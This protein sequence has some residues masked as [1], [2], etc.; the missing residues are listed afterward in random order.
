MGLQNLLRN[1]VKKGFSYMFSL[2]EDFKSFL[3]TSPTSWHAVR[4]VGNRLSMKDFHPL[5]ENQPWELEKGKKYFVTRGGSIGT[6]CL[7]K[8]APS[9][10][11]LMAAHTDSPSFK[12]KPIPDIHQNGMSL[13]EVESYGS[14]ILHSWLNRDIA[15]AGRIFFTNKKDELQEELVFMDDVPMIIPELAIHLHREVN[16]KGPLLNKQEHLMPLFSLQSKDPITLEGLLRRCFSFKSLISFDL[17]LVPLEPSRFLG[18]QGD[19]ISS[20]RIDNLASVHA[21]TCAMATYEGSSILPLSVFW[22]HEE[23]GSKSW[24][25][26]GSSF[27]NDLLTRIKSFY[28]LT[29]EEFLILK[30]NSLCF[31]LD[32]AHGL[33][34]MHLQKHDPNH[35]PLLGQGITFKSNADLKYASSG[36]TLSSAIQICKKA[37]LPFQHFVIRSDLVCGSTVG[38]TIT[39]STGIPTVDLGCAQLSMHSSRE[40]MAVQD[41]LDLNTFLAQALKP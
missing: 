33:N 6:F 28:Q 21:A 18:V 12:V 23:I 4:Q 35:Q 9:K 13:L 3:D 27:L 8:E 7:P 14:P 34:P 41:Y 5:E 39:A 40:I 26:A 36:Y 38:P 22:D 17:H 10:I 32:M 24:E 20:Y 2:I 29:E 16:E 25:G 11:I 1:A 37:N 30:R 15:L 31:S 19:M